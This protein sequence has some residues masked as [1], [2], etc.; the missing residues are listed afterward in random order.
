MPEIKTTP[1]SA[2]FLVEIGGSDV[3][4]IEFFRCGGMFDELT[5]TNDPDVSRSERMIQFTEKQWEEFK[6]FIDSKI[7]E[8]NCIEIKL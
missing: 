3:L 5:I 7:K 4:N 6:N 8:S 1:E 2:S